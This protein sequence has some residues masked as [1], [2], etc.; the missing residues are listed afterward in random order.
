MDYDKLRRQICFTAAQLLN[1]RQ[2]TN[3]T[4]AR[5]RAARSITRSYIDPRSV[6]T[7]MEI[8]MALQQLVTDSVCDV[9]TALSERDDEHGLPVGRFEQYRILLE[10]LDRVLLNRDTH[11]EGD[12]LYHS[13][14]VFELAE[15]AR[16]WDEEFLTAAL[17][18][19][20]GRG[21]DPF[22]A[23]VATLNAIRD[24]VSDR[25]FWLV[26]NLPIQHRFSDGTIGMRARRRLSQHDDGDVL[27][28]L[29]R[30]DSEGRVPGRAVR[31]LE[32][33]I[34]GLRDL[35]GQ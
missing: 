29:A 16:P 19:E 8:R 21:I 24:F 11:P 30:C 12:L 7:D 25:T 28:M 1:A 15:A 33:V 10:P 9:D 17:L 3:F 18:H 14:Q 34:A 4:R 2:E 6:P 5:W 22:A 35:A 13:L 32:Q 27:Q 20:V 26:E 23:H 31:S